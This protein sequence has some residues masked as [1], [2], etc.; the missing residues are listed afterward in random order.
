MAKQEPLLDTEWLLGLPDKP[1]P[2]RLRF[3]K[4]SMIALGLVVIGVSVWPTLSKIW[5]H[6]QLVQQYQ[7]SESAQTRNEAMIALAEMLPQSMPIV[8]AGLAKSNP[9]EAH[10]A[11]EALDYYIGRVIAL[12]LEQRRAIFAELIHAIE[13]ATP[14]LPRDSTLLARALASRVSAAQQSD[15]HPG[16]LVML[17]ACQRINEQT[18]SR[19][20]ATLVSS[21][22]LS[23]LTEPIQPKQTSPLR[24]LVSDMSDDENT[25]ASETPAKEIATIDN[26]LAAV[27]LVLKSSNDD[28]IEPPAIE[29]S[30]V[31]SSSSNLG[32]LRQKLH[33]AN[34]FTPVNGNVSFAIQSNSYSS[35]VDAGQ[36]SIA[37]PAESK[38]P[39]AAAS[40]RIVAVEEEFIS[41]G[42]QQT[43]ELIRLLSSV[44]PRL[45]SAAF[46]ELQRSRLSQKELDIAVELSQ[47]TTE[48]RLRTMERLVKESDL[49]PV[50]WLTWM[51]SEA[52]REVRLKAVSLLGSL[53][54]EDARLKLRL[55]NNR[56]RDPDISRQIQNALLASGTNKP[57][58]R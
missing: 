39:N 30:N 40:N 36:F 6:D 27:H 19:T 34:R 50:T 48:Q 53:N 45:A 11:Y 14:N 1:G 43:E 37:T 57:R 56:E 13:A 18:Q 54:S 17:A 26:A 42:R 32:Q 23:D 52:D 47:G 44:Q 8:I 24:A 35:D 33:L 3:L 25:I 55:M 49:N 38:T 9:D 22:K 10:L 7:T 28:E 58:N 31:S 46:H 51:G 16:S 29:R 20:L 15:Q 4:Q 2:W 41:I 5:V 21:A 12:P